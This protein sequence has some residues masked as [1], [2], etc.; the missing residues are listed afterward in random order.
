MNFLMKK[1]FQQEIF[2]IWKNGT[3]FIHQA[4]SFQKWLIRLK[5][6]I[7]LNSL[8]LQ[9]VGAEIS[10]NQKLHQAGA[11][12][13]FPAIFGFV[14][15]RHHVEIVTKCK[16]IE[17]AL[18]YVRKTIEESW[19]STYDYDCRIKTRWTGND[20]YSYYELY[21][22]DYLHLCRFVCI[23]DLEYLCVSTRNRR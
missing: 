19:S 3:C 17:E 6:S 2:G 1:A 11:E 22:I 16:T 14:P 7:D 8:K 13:E 23:L 12:I 5:K 9:Q 15:W 4:I 10:E 18:F 21:E 20:D